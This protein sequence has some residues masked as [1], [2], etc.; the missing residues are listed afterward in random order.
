[1]A[2]KKVG[3]GEN[4]GQVTQGPGIMELPY[5]SPSQAPERNVLLGPK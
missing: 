4:I 3:D 2:R 1:M 5:A